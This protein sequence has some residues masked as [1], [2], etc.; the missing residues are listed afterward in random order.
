MSIKNQ[1]LRIKLIPVDSLLF[2]ASLTLEEKHQRLFEISR[3]RA[4]NLKSSIMSSSS[5]INSTEEDELPM[6][7]SANAIHTSVQRNQAGFY[8]SQILIGPRQY[9]PYLIV[10]PGSDD[11]WVQCEGCI[12]CLP[13]RYGNFR[14]Q[15]SSS[16][17][18]LPCN[19]PLCVPN[20]CENCSATSTTT[21]NDAQNM[22]N[23][24]LVFGCGLDNQDLFEGAD[25][26]IGGLLGLASG[27]RS[28]LMQLA[29]QTKRRFTYSGSGSRRVQTTGL[30]PG[31]PRHYVK[32]MGISIEGRLLAI[33]PAVFRNG[34]VLYAKIS[35][36]TSA[37]L[38]AR[39]KSFLHGN[40]GTSIFGAFQQANYRFL[41]DV[42]QNTMS[43]VPEIC[44]VYRQ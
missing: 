14:Y 41:F 42:S 11:T 10:D 8:L 20:I 21:D 9:S 34:S 30:L 35:M 2:P 40:V 12:N 29:D 31:I 17:H 1:S 3:I 44:Q 43:F 37:W 23:V 19:H 39:G 13:L 5:P 28:N 16:F 18:T 6:K 26:V 33:N 27:Q 36:A 38:T 7:N 24:P 4:L 32:P 15:Q 25:N 22:V